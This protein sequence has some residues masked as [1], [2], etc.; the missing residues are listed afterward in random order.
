MFRKWVNKCF[1]MTTVEKTESICFNQIKKL[2][3][4]ETAAK[5]PD[6]NDKW[7]VIGFIDRANNICESVLGG[8]IEFVIQNPNEIVNKNTNRIKYIVNMY[9]KKTHLIL[10]KLTFYFQYDNLQMGPVLI[11]K[12]NIMNDLSSNH[13]NFI[14]SVFYNMGFRIKKKYHKLP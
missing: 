10:N 12:P 7:K 13:W 1:G 6:I 5:L 11:I 2:I 4:F 8:T 9:N 3:I 14:E